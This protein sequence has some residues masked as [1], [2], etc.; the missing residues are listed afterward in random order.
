[1]DT[2]LKT[3][4]QAIQARLAAVAPDASAEDLVMLAKAVEAV[5]GRATVFDVLDAGEEARQQGVSAI[6]AARIAALAEVHAAAGVTDAMLADIAALF[7]RL[8]PV[9]LALTKVVNPLPDTARGAYVLTTVSNATASVRLPG[10]VPGH[11]A[12]GCYMLINSSTFVV[13]VEDATGDHVGALQPHGFAIAYI[14]GNA[15][16]GWRWQLTRSDEGGANVLFD[17][18]VMLLDAAGTQYMQIVAMDEGYVVAWTVGTTVRLCLLRWQDGQLVPGVIEQ[19]PTAYV[20]TSFSL[21]RLGATPRC[22]LLYA[23]PT[24]N[25]QA[26]RAFFVSI[27]TSGLH[28]SDIQT[29]ATEMSYTLQWASCSMISATDGVVFWVSYYSSSPS[30]YPRIATLKISSQSVISLGTT[31]RVFQTNNGWAYR[32]SFGHDT[33]GSRALLMES[34][35][36]SGAPILHYFSLSDVS[37][38][39]AAPS[40]IIGSSSMYGHCVRFLSD[41]LAIVIWVQSATQVYWRLVSLTDTSLSFTSMGMLNIPDFGWGSSDRLTLTPLVLAANK[42]ALVTAGTLAGYPKLTLGTLNANAT[43][44]SWE[45][46][47]DL[48]FGSKINGMYITAGYDA[49]RQSLLIAQYSTAASPLALSAKV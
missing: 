12:V 11:G 47:I 31:T 17:Q 49:V 46:S 43:D 23:D 14:T 45:P 18:P 5:G 7:G 42:V 6:D 21:V 27:D 44:I 24:S 15:D 10:Y 19:H 20:S 33:L 13:Q 30:Y 41:S 29:L 37:K 2:T 22:M 40:W 26:V 1:M 36:S 16:A 35:Y 8:D 25:N 32:S 9:Q 39:I 4:V 38:D 3:Q 34:G 28:L 48:P